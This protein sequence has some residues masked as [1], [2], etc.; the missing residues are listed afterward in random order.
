[1]IR[2]ILLAAVYGL[3]LGCA[4]PRPLVMGPSLSQVQA[5]PT[6]YQG[7]RIRWGGRIARVDNEAHDTLIEVVQLP[8]DSA[9]KPLAATTSEGRFMAHFGRFL[10][11]VIYAPGKR[12][13]VTGTVH[14]TRSGLIGAHPYRYPVVEV[15]RDQLWPEHDRPQIIYYHDPWWPGPYFNLYP[16]PYP[17]YWR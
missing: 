7:R 8:L 5:D 11:P 2:I 13:T 14:G 16:W 6:A 15:T 4:T 12:L 3:L 9:G 17:D 10:D 1:M